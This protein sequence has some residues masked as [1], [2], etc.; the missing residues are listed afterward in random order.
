MSYIITAVAFLVI[1][2]LLVLIHEWGHYKMAKR[3]K[4]KVEE[5]GFGLPPKMLTMFK[6]NG[7]DF[8]LN[9]IPFGGFVRM[10][11]EDDFS[12]KAQKDKDSF[13]SKT[14]WQR[15]GVIVAGVVMN[16]VLALFLL[17]VGFSFGMPP[18]LVSS[19]DIQQAIS[20]GVLVVEESAVIADIID[21]SPA[22]GSTLQAGD[23][24]IQINGLKIE[25]SQDI[26]DVQAE[27]DTATYLVERGEDQIVAEVKPDDEGKIGII[28]AN[29]QTPLEV[30][31]VS[32]PV[33]KAVG[34]AFYET[35]RLSWL[36]VQ[37]LGNVVTSLVKEASVPEGV[38]GPVGIL[39]LTHH[40]AQE[41]FMALLQLCAVLSLSL[42]VIN[43]MPFPALD[44][45]R[46]LFI[47]YE[48][49]TRKK[50]NRKAEGYI[51]A[52]GFMLLLLLI[53]AVTWKDIVRIFGG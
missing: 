15:T 35:G 9:W 41:G 51:H 30:K 12:E 38:A 33:H 44:G 4:I 43:I 23:K 47:I 5:F 26:L 34:M 40:Y 7:T 53:F 32:Y 3:A 27:S 31:K 29:Q 10:F 16:Y 28:I 17:T 46:L 45:G 50:V 8:T 42:A 6:K 14:L 21:G 13:Q 11:G 22:A 19:D 36:T 1:F 49:I 48:A 25:Q 37:M 52:A 24:I 39:Q 2:T 18:I 20:D